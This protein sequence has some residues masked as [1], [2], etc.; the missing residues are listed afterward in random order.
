[1]YTACDSSSNYLFY[2]PYSSAS[3]PKAKI[4]VS[5]I[6]TRITKETMNEDRVVF[7]MLSSGW[8][9]FRML[10]RLWLHIIVKNEAEKSRGNAAKSKT[11]CV[12]WDS[13]TESLPPAM[14][15]A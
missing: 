2:Y 15:I 5:I 1:M 13:E 11:P 12:G 4:D 6:S 7:F 14:M 8:T 9:G 3:P 10:G